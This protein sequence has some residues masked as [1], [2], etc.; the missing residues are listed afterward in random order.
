[1]N[2][3]L[4][5]IGAVIP[6]LLLLSQGNAQALWAQ[7]SW[8]VT[9]YQSTVVEDHS[10]VRIGEVDLGEYGYKRVDQYVLTEQGDMF[11][12]GDTAVEGSPKLSVISLKSHQKMLITQELGWPN[13]PDQIHLMVFYLNDI[14][15]AFVLAEYAD[16]N[17]SR[18]TEEGT[19]Y[20][21]LFRV[22]PEEEKSVHLRH[23]TLTVTMIYKDWSPDAKYA[24][25]DFSEG[26]GANVPA[27]KERMKYFLS[28]VNGDG[29]ADILIW[30]GT[31]QARSHGD[32]GKGDFY[33]AGA[34]VGVMYF[35]PQEKTFSPITP[36]EPE[37]PIADY[38]ML[39]R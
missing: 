7:A 22:V 23:E 3:Q 38:E 19:T 37:R 36:I 26:G 21:D 14:S 28:D 12:I 6:S 29:Y 25:V 34:T 31:Y 33:L 16:V 27:K 5:F 24:Y 35:Q 30:K 8:S 1:M 11:I 10:S 17:V 13:H 20:L 2:T 32:P 15:D 39:V 9:C 18:E 4:Q